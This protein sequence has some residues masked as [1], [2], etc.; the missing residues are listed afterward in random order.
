[1]RGGCANIREQ[2]TS[3]VALEQRQWKL[4]IPMDVFSL[5]TLATYIPGAFDLD[6][7]TSY[8][9]LGSLLSNIAPPTTPR[10]RYYYCR[11]DIAGQGSNV[12]SFTSTPNVGPLVRGKQRWRLV[13]STPCSR[14]EI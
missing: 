4:F 8:F 6:E 5:S 1:M 7:T 12:N 11:G 10:Y 2:R 9:I 13:H 3:G 14:Y